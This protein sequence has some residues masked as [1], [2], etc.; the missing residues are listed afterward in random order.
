MAK[1]TASRAH[2]G[3]GLNSINS[4][5][6]LISY[7]SIPGAGGLTLGLGEEPVGV[8]LAPPVPELEAAASRGEGPAG[9]GGP[10][11]TDLPRREGTHRTT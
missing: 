5:F 9:E 4:S 10:A 7:M 8:P 1:L 11:G 2:R 6:I 3:A